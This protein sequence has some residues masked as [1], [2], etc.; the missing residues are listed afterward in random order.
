[1]M[2]NVHDIDVDTIRFRMVASSLD[3]FRIRL[4][5]RRKI[6]HILSGGGVGR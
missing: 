1:M 2:H 5:D 3:Y 4:S 6:R